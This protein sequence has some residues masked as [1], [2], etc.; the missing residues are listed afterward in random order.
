MKRSGIRRSSP[1][2]VRDW[3]DRSKPLRRAS[4][5]DNEAAGAPL[6]KLRRVKRGPFR[7][8]GGGPSDAVKAEVR[9]RDG[10]RCRPRYSEECSGGDDHVHHIWLR[11]AGGPDT[12]WNLV[13]VCWR[14][15]NAIHAYPAAAEA[16][17]WYRHRITDE[18][19]AVVAT[20]GLVFALADV[21]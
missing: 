13:T 5:T 19:R 15:H 4:P 12:A 16:A 1:E 2:K 17:G 8:R 20:G 14:C 9:A 6:P 11:S 10:H 7:R 18:E 21:A 3:Q